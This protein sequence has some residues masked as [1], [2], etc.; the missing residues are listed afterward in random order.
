MHFS[1][2]CVWPTRG[3]QKR[4]GSEQVPVGSEKQKLCLATPAVGSCKVPTGSEYFAEDCVWRARGVQNCAH[5]KQVPVVSGRKTL[6]FAHT[7]CRFLRGSRR[8][9]TYS[10]LQNI[11]FVR[12]R[13]GPSFCDQAYESLFHSGEICFALGG[14]VG[15]M[16]EKIQQLFKLHGWVQEGQPRS[17]GR[18]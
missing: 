2:Y 11:R 15:H 3:V 12:S 14:E 18:G 8:F 6:R 17:A 7:S 4:T 9:H 1:E 5:A 10:M 13:C 16:V